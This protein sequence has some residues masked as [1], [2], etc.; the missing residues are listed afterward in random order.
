MSTVTMTV[1]A[2]EQP[3]LVSMLT[4]ILTALTAAAPAVKPVVP[5]GKLA[6]LLQ[7]GTLKAGDRLSF[8]QPRAKRVAFATVQSDGA[9][10]V[11][12]VP[13]RYYAPSP[14]ATAVTGN[15]IDGWTLWR[16]TGDGAL[17]DS[18]R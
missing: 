3:A 12:G 9:L 18:L 6:P 8:I 11:D 17:L 14:A 5:R 10:V 13:G 16:R 2:A 7:A 4:Q 15:S 1:P